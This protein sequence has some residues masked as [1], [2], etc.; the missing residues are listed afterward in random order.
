MR[1]MTMTEVKTNIG[2][3]DSAREEDIIL[4]KY[5]KPYLQVSKPKRV[6]S[7]AKFSG[8]SK[9]VTSDLKDELERGLKEKYENNA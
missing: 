7:I 5:G 8:A 2:L 3:L 4:T 1:T 9:E 6:S